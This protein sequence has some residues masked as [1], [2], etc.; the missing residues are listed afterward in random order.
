MSRFLAH[1]E[2]IKPHLQIRGNRLLIELLPKEELKTAGGIIIKSDMSGYKTQTEDSRPQM[3]LVL[4]TG[5]ERTNSDGYLEAGTNYEPGNVLWITTH[6]TYISEFPGL[7]ATENK[8]AW[9]T[10]NPQ[11]IHVK[12]ASLTAYEEFKKVSRA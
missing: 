6:P 9:I 11:D 2:R 10:D 4:A 12:W 3:A 7:G 5:D 8:L 1:F